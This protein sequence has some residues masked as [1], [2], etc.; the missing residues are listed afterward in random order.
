[1]AAELTGVRPPVGLRFL[2]GSTLKASSRPILIYTGIA[3]LDSGHR[4]RRNRHAPKASR[5]GL[6]KPSQANND[7]VY[8]S[9]VR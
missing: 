7:N 4:R 8:L 6:R 3:D 2:S 9:L 5:D 1:M